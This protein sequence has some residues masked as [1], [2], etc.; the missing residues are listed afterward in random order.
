ML[1]ACAALCLLLSILAADLARCETKTSKARRHQNNRQGPTQGE[2]LIGGCPADLEH[3]LS[4]Y[5][6]RWYHSLDTLPACTESTSFSKTGCQRSQSLVVA[7]TPT[8]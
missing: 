8:A 2:T 3:R 4:L 1:R 6:L 5:C 7:V